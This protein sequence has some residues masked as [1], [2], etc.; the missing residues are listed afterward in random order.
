M[1]HFQIIPK[2][3]IKSYFIGVSKYQELTVN[4][5]KISDKSVHVRVICSY[6]VDKDITG[7]GR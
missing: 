6:S 5:E 3:E 2:I 7:H 4:K 1:C